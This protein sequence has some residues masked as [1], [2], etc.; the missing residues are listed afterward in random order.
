MQQASTNSG[1][2]S[3]SNSG[4]PGQDESVD[5]GSSVGEGVALADRV[6]LGGGIEAVTNVC[7]QQM[8]E[9]LRSLNIPATV[10]I[11]PTGTHSWGYW[12]RELHASWPAIAR[13]LK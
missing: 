2:P 11:R 7:T 5:V 9:K 13:S 8:A 4:L 6:I 3:S 12:E 10:V 1:S